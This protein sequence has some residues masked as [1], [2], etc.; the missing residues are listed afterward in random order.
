MKW[1]FSASGRGVRGTVLYVLFVE[2]A[3]LGQREESENVAK[4]QM[5]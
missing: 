4:N 1:K 2:Q 3:K 5:G